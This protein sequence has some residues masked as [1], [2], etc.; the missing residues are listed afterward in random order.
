MDAVLFVLIGGLF[1][2]IGA[3]PVIFF[4][5]RGGLNL[6]WWL[7]AAPFFVAGA[8]LPVT[9][10]GLAPIWQLP[11]PVALAFTI[12]ATLAASFA[13]ALTTYTLG[14]H[15]RR[16]ALWHQSD[17]AP[18]EIVTDGPYRLVR[19]PFYTAFLAALL[20][21]V[22]AAPSTVTL[23]CLLWGFA[24]LF[25]T[26]RREERRLLGSTLGATYEA[27]MRRTGHFL[28]LRG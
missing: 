12:L 25:L 27:Y 17:D 9:Y 21:A 8:A 15:R 6:R 4:Q 16:I 24:A 2:L 11:Q 1:A 23:V 20:A 3:L 22:F 7:T 10:L 5:R 28:P 26:A 13:L 14:I 18:E 19:H